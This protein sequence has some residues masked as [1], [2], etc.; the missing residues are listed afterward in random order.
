MAKSSLLGDT[1]LLVTDGVVEALGSDRTVF[2]MERLAE[3]FRQ[4]GCG[5]SQLVKDIFEEIGR[6]SPASPEYDSTVLAVTGTPQPAG[7]PR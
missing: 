6:I 4:E 3:I 5:G 1:L 2:K 7:V